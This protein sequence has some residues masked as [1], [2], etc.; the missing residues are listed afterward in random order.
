MTEWAPSHFYTATKHAVQALSEG[1][2]QELHSMNSHIRIC[3]C[4]Y[5]NVYHINLY[6]VI[7]NILH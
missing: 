4:I 3:V 7:Q 5:S 1:L 6:D 2:R